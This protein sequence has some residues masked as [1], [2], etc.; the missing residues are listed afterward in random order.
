MSI[1]CKPC[2]KCSVYKVHNFKFEIDKTEA[3]SRLEA[4]TTCLGRQQ[5]YLTYRPKTLLFLKMAEQLATSK[6][7]SKQAA[8]SGRKKPVNI[9][10]SRPPPSTLKIH[11]VPGQAKKKEQR[12]GKGKKVVVA[13]PEHYSDDGANEESAADGI[14]LQTLSLTKWG[15][16]KRA[17][18]KVDPAEKLI[19]IR[20][21]HLSGVMTDASEEQRTEASTGVGETEDSMA[22][23]ATKK[24]LQP[25]KG[26]VDAALQPNEQARYDE[27]FAKRKLSPSIYVDL[28]HVKSELKLD[29]DVFLKQYE[30]LIG[31]HLRYSPIVVRNFYCNL[32]R[33]DV[34]HKDGERREILLQ[35]TV[36]GKRF[37]LSAKEI[38]EWLG[39][40][41]PPADGFVDRSDDEVLAVLKP[42]GNPKGLHFKPSSM[43]EEKRVLW[44]IYT[45]CIVSKGNNFTCFYRRDFTLFASL[46]AKDTR[47]LGVMIMTELDT[48]MDNASGTGCLP[49][50]HLVSLFLDCNKIWYLDRADGIFSVPEF[51]RTQLSKMGLTVATAHGEAVKV[52][53]KRRRPEPADEVQSSRGATQEPTPHPPSLEETVRQVVRE[54]LENL[55]NS[56]DGVNE[57]VRKAMQMLDQRTREILDRLEAMLGRPQPANE[58]SPSSFQPAQAVVETTAAP[59]LDPVPHPFTHDLSPRLPSPPISS[60]HASPAVSPTPYSPGEA[61][62]IIGEVVTR[63]GEENEQANSEN[64]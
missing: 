19:P 4:Q 27:F 33:V 55:L 16:G 25:P 47:N 62:H 40:R 22:A 46:V 29:L 49:F 37:Q 18:R 51:G 61:E 11:D 5:K 21:T 45:R 64:E 54:E 24:D 52:Q 48:W 44:Y 57:I 3:L 6:D 30:P 43:S 59:P 41:E 23:D 63:I 53:R 58:Q 12:K 20:R 10:V 56:H 26:Y 42:S 34:R 31:N 28:Q 36:R 2:I 32:E 8:Y 38:N 15:A 13:S 7:T 14:L 9:H 60:G 35:T 39:I 50:P 17:H 1:I